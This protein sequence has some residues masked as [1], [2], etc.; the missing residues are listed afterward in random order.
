MRLCQLNGPLSA[1]SICR[2]LPAL[3]PYSLYISRYLSVPVSVCANTRHTH[4]AHTNTAAALIIIM[5]PLI[6]MRIRT[7]VLR[8]LYKQL[9][10][11]HSTPPP[12]FPLIPD[13]SIIWHYVGASPPLPR[14][15]L[16]LLGFL[17]QLCLFNI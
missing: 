7:R 5:S 9:P 13:D 10:S 12:F 16:P 8:V 14:P 6:A 3:S 15:H 17:R 11:V 1:R 2:P 4:W